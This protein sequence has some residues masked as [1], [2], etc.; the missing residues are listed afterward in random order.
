MANIHKK[1][2]IIFGAIVFIALITIFIVKRRKK[3]IN[4]SALDDRSR[5]TVET[6]D[7]RIQKQAVDFYTQAKNAAM[8]VQIVSGMRS[9][10]Q[11]Q[12]LYD[13]GRTKPGTIVTNAKAGS[14]WHNY[15]LAFDFVPAEGYNSKNWDKLGAIGKRNGLEWGG[16][17]TSFKD[18]P[19]FQN[20]LGLTIKQA[21]NK[22]RNNNGFII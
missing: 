22:K 6:L 19:H 15:G 7:P 12:A 11:Q 14:S 18:R 21:I 10:E 20:R 17:W 1:Y 9:F 2:I 3:K 16:D 13:K 5:K 4:F 8:P